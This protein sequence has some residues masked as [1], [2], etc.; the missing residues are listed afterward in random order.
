MDA[1]GLAVA[2]DVVTVDRAQEPPCVREGVL[3]LSSVLAFGVGVG[4]RVRVRVRGRGRVRVRGKVSGF[5]CSHT[6]CPRGTRVS[7]T[8]W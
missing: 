3:A 1:V 6:S 8:T 2:D 7:T 5:T 4:V